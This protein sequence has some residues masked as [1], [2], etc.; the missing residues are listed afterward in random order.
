MF[1]FRRLISVFAT[2]LILDQI[3]LTLFEK[4]ISKKFKCIEKVIVKLA[5]AL[6][7]FVPLNDAKL[8]SRKSF[9]R[10]SKIITTITKY[11]RYVL[12]FRL[13][14]IFGRYN[15]ATWNFLFFS[16]HSFFPQSTHL[17]SQLPKDP[18]WPAP[19]PLV[20]IIRRGNRRELVLERTHR[21]PKYNQPI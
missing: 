2:R 8:I 4:E 11:S 17:H 18:G 21:L 19:E 9:V 10:V 5:K 14:T 20:Y 3:V 12:L 1:S 6:L 16:G 7:L 13:K 15:A